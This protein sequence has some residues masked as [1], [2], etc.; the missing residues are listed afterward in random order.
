MFKKEASKGNTRKFLFIDA[1]YSGIGEKVAKYIKE[2][3]Y[4]KKS[5]L[6]TNYTY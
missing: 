5:V 2:S 3:R 4:E 1:V 6:F